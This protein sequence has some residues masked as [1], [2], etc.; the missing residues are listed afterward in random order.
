MMLTYVWPR[1][2]SVEPKID[3]IIILR[4]KSV[5]SFSSDSDICYC[6]Y[7]HMKNSSQAETKVVRQASL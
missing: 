3:L 6:N 5:Y 2:D 4:K 1:F 7:T